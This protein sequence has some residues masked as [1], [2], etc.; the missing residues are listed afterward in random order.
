[1]RRLV[2][3]VNIGLGACPISIPVGNG[4]VEIDA[5]PRAALHPM[6]G[7][8]FFPR[9]NRDSVPVAWKAFYNASHLVIREVHF[10]LKVVQGGGN[11]PL[12]ILP[13]V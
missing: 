10:V 13:S 3:Q 11:D 4:H 7:F 6:L 9:H 1:M 5:K 12:D 8:I 2:N